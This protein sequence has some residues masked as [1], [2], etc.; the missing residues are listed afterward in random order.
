MSFLS[1]SENL[2]NSIDMKESTKNSHLKR[3]RVLDR[4][5]ENVDNEG[6]RKLIRY[7]KVIKI[8]NQKYKNFNTRKG[9]Y[10][11]ILM[12]LREMNKQ[13]TE[14]HNNYKL[15][16]IITNDNVNDVI[17]ENKYSSREKE[18]LIKWEDIKKI[19]PIGYNHKI[20]Y[21]FIVKENLF[22]RLKIFSIKLKDYDRKRD[23]YI[24][25]KTLYL[26][27]FKNVEA[28]NKGSQKFRLKKETI[29]LI[30]F[31][32]DYLININDGTQFIKKFFKKYTKNEVNDV[33]LRK[34]YINHHLQKN[35]SNKKLQKK[36]DRMLNNLSDWN[37]NYRKTDG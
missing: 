36:A 25:G 27:D 9:Y 12:L 22:L 37:T 1:K 5:L 2:L 33:L 15:Q 10:N 29:D 23:N 28:V 16:L 13:G 19:N 3:I 4:L 31:N 8:I 35:L 24:K 11:T 21:Q 17:N 14:E 18:K 7:D 6:L 26:N 32:Q 34:I 30:N 20:F